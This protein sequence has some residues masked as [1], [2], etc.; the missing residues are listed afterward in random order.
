MGCWS[1][2]G[3]GQSSELEMEAQVMG[4]LSLR[5]SCEGHQFVFGGEVRSGG[6]EL[7]GLCAERTAAEFDFGFPAIASAKEITVAIRFLKLRDD[8]FDHEHAGPAVD[9]AESNVGD[10]AMGIV[11]TVAAGDADDLMNHVDSGL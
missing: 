11:T 2:A 1:F 6:Q 8:F 3:Y 4:F 7:M 10:V 5:T 9:G